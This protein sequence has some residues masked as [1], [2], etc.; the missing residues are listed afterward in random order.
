MGLCMSRTKSVPSSP[1]PYDV[2]HKCSLAE[3]DDVDA[4]DIATLVC[5]KLRRDAWRNL[6]KNPKNLFTVLDVF[7]G[8]IPA[9]WVEW[10]WHKVMEGIVT[11]FVEM[12]GDSVPDRALFERSLAAA[13]LE[14]HVPFSPSMVEYTIIPVLI[15]LKH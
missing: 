12:C 4:G 2:A 6:V 10:R 14:Q 13:L 15:E 11:Y 7:P 1:P 9:A 3:E 8:M 5:E